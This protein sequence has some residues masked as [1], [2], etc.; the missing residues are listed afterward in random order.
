MPFFFSVIEPRLTE[1]LEPIRGAIAQLDQYDWILFTSVNAVHFF[2]DQV[3]NAI[4]PEQ[5]L[6][7]LSEKKLAAIGPKTEKALHAYGLTADAVP[8]VFHQEALIE[9]CQEQLSPGMR[10]LYPRAQMARRKLTAELREQGITVDDIVL[11]TSVVVDQQKEELLHLLQSGEIDV[12]TFT[13]SSTVKH[14]VDLFEM[15]DW[16]RYLHTLTIASIGPIT[17][18]TAQ[19]SGLEVQIEAKEFTSDSLIEEI[20]RY[21]QGKT[22]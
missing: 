16:R 15:T 18:Q 20:E 22:R 8:T 3:K 13:S 6:K 11:Y 7:W 19:E 2:V 10:V 9:T 21:Y 17:T 5:K 12:I 1:D 4:H 14:F